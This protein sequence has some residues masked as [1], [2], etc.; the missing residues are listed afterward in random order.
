MSTKP[1]NSALWLT[2][3]DQ[4]LV[5]VLCLLLVG[6]IELPRLGQHWS[7]MVGSPGSAPINP[8]PGYQVDLNQA[9]EDELSLLVAIGPVRAAA[10]VRERET[11]GPYRSVDDLQR[12]KGIGPKTVEKNRRWATV[13]HQQDGP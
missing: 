3:R 8:L 1:R 4:W 12:V 6:W 2:A 5:F 11:G 7:A 10:V 9:S 13:T